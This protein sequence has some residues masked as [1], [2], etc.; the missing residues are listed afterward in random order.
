MRRPLPRPPTDRPTPPPA[1]RKARASRRPA[2]PEGFR[3]GTATSAY[4]V[5]GAAREDGRGPS[6]RDTFTREPGRIRD[7][8]TGDVSVDHYN[9]Y[10]EDVAPRH[11]ARLWQ[12]KDIFITENG[13][14]AAD[15]PAA[16]GIVYDVDR[17]MFLRV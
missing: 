5:E 8:P 11:A 10:E 14:S 7:G 6:I 12:V 9:R 17:V 15:Q 2:F 1:H 4:Q 13:T 16:D 3:W